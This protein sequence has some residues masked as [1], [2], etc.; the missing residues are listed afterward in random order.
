VRVPNFFFYFESL[1]RQEKLLQGV[2]TEIVRMTS[3][4]QPLEVG[5]PL[6]PFSR[7]TAFVKHAADSVMAQGPP[8]PTSSSYDEDIPLP[9]K[10][11][12]RHLEQPA[13]DS[14]VTWHQSSAQGGTA[15]VFLT[16]L[17]NVIY[18]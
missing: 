14:P 16:E 1:A 8:L 3:Q 11:S 2:M 5:V 18:P 6:Y 4:M 12:P 13:R 15:S 10:A 9:L 7:E 17:Q